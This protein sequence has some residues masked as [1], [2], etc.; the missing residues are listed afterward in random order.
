M[1]DL[2]PHVK[3]RWSLIGPLG[4]ANQEI[5]EA[6]RRDEERRHA[7]LAEPRRLLDRLLAQLE[8]LNLEDVKVVPETCGPAMAELRHQLAGLPK[9]GPRLVERLQPGGRTA[10]VIETI[11]T[12]EEII[13][14]PTLAPGTVPLDDDT[15]P[16]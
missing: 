1:A 7:R 2:P 13:A 3:G 14:P 4:S 8:E 12:I 16:V 9:V 5:R 11:F 10:D 15:D 6:Q